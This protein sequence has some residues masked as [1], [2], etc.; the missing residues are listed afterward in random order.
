MVAMVSEGYMRV[1]VVAQEI[2]AA[3]PGWAAMLL[4]L[5]HYCLG[6]W[7]QAFTLNVPLP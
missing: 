4:L 3:C 1:M 5:Q 6:L 7:E 2:R